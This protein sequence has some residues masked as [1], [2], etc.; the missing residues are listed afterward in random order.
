[1]IKTEPKLKTLTTNDKANIIETIS[2]YII[3]RD[4]NGIAYYMPYMKDDAMVIAFTLYVIDG[5]NFES[6]DDIFDIYTKDKDI[7]TLVTCFISNNI[8]LI[9][10]IESYVDDVVEFKK[11]YIIHNN[12]ILTN[13]I[14]EILDSQKVFEDYKYELAKTENHILNQQIEV[15]NRQ[16]EIMNHLTPEEVAELDKRMLSGEYDQQKIADAVVKSYINTVATDKE[17]VVS[18]PKRKKTS[19]TSSTKTKK[20]TKTAKVSTSESNK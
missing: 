20:S 10:E 3:G 19:T 12:P 16:L 7:N 15:N 4:E 5:V 13:K 18:M 11:S 1:M 14:V 9:A 8:K 17:N 6:N 2:D